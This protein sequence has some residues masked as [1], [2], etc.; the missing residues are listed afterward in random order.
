MDF[1]IIKVLIITSK[2]IS[3][4]VVYGIELIELMPKPL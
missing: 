1:R 3:R 4:V 2:C